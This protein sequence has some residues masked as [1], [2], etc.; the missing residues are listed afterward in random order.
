MKRA[1]FFP[2]G[3]GSAAGYTGRC[4]ALATELAAAGWRCAFAPSSV[5]SMVEEAGFE[6]VSTEAVMPAASYRRVPDYISIVNI[7]QMLAVSAGFHRAARVRQ[8]VE[9]DRETVH[10]FEPDVVV[11]DLSPTAHLVARSRGLP[12]VALADGDFVSASPKAW[13]PWCEADPGR[14][15]PYR[16]CLDALNEASEAI[17]GPVLERVTDAI[18]GDVTLIPSTASLDPIDGLSGDRDVRYIGPLYWDPPPAA[19]LELPDTDAAKICVTIGSGTTASRR[20]LDSTFK[21]LSAM[22]VVAFVAMGAAA[23]PETLAG[24]IVTG[25]FAG[26]SRPLAW[27]D[28]VV[29]HGGYSSVTATLRAAKPSVVLPFMSEQEA[30]G[31]AMVVD[32]HAGVLA[33]TSRCDAQTGKTSF[34]FP[35]GRVSG[36]PTPHPGEM[37]DAIEAAS[38]RSD[39]SALRA[40][41]S[42]LE[43]CASERDLVGAVEA[44]AT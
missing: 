37:R 20:A 34:E 2:W 36:D 7:D 15:L 30:N 9:V 28:V 14:V 38:A 25:G 33:R 41:S 12:I 40:L 18:W 8:Q 5:R 42:A 13:M 43:A 4:L 10:R 11:I 19:D 17:G 29:N 16:S 6:I 44:V 31:R 27:A 1:L 26:L 24:N 21:A 35:T 32:Q 23:S 39:P 3:W 22:D